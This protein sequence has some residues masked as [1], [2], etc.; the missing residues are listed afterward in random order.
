MSKET[1][2]L[3]HCPTNMIADM[4]TKGQQYDKQ[5]EQLSGSEQGEKYGHSYQTMYCLTSVLYALSFI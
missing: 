5:P 3:K 2:K 4:L 1:V